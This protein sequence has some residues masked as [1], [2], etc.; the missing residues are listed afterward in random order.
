MKIAVQNVTTTIQK[1]PII[2]DM[3]LDVGSGECIGIIGPNG[4]GKST[5]LKSIYR[6][7]PYD[8]GEIYVDRIDWAACSAKEAAKYMAVVSQEGAAQ[9]DFSVEEMVLM[10]RSP[11]KKWFEA[12]SDDDR[13]VVKRALEQVG[14]WEDRERSFITLSGGEKQRVMIARAIAQQA[15][16]L[17]LDEPTNHLDIHHQLQVMEIARELGV[18]IIAA[19][20]DLNIA[21]AYCDR[22]YVVDNGEIVASGTPA[23]VLTEQLLRRVFQVE[24]DVIIHPKTNS[25]HIT[26]LPA[27]SVAAVAEVSR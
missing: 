25:V 20:H 24:T 27:R 5:L 23:E 9:F 21:A 17:V 15:Q 10:G 11:H 22:I 2:Q 4:S 1:R 7:L 6:A 3:S 16:I 12:D 14:L 18:T 26:Y 8:A 19:L 13:R